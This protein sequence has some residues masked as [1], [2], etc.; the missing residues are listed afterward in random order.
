[1]PIPNPDRRFWKLAILAAGLV[2]A[3][4]GDS[5][6]SGESSGETATEETATETDIAAQTAKEDSAPAGDGDKPQKTRASDGLPGFTGI[7]AANRDAVVNISTTRKVEGSGPAMPERFEGTP[8]EDFF[9][10][11]FEGPE[12][13]TQSLGSG[14]IVSGDGHIVTNAHVVKNASKVVVQLADRRQL[15]AE[16]LGKDLATD[17]AVLKVA[18][19]GLPSL[20]W[21]EGA[22]PQVGEWVL[23]L[24][25][26]FGFEHSATAGI[27]SA[28]GR[29]IPGQAGSYVP[30]LQ[31][32][33]ALN[34]GS[35]GGPLFNPDGEVV[36]VNAQIYSKSGGYMGLSFAIPSKV[37]RDVVA[38][39]RREGEVSHGYLGVAVQDMNRELAR[40]LGLDK[41]RGG[42][43]ARVR[44]GTPA[45]EAGLETG[46]VILAVNGQEIA[47]AGDIPP[48]VGR[49]DPGSEVMLTLL[50]AEQRMDKTVTLGALAEAPGK[51][52]K[53]ASEPTSVLGMRLA[54]VPDELRQR[55]PLPEAG[56][57]LVKGVK[58]GP[59]RRAGIHPGDVILK[60]GDARIE[61]PGRVADLIG[62]VDSG[63]RVPVMIQRG[64]HT[65]FVPL[66]VP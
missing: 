1:M 12:R 23:A 17:L 15:E 56:G 59:A 20:T 64:E 21:S 57:A 43:I 31:T 25:S 10:R 26:P 54:P 16:V 62:R 61:G 22:G 28:R 41:P 33:V 39:I 58:P 34:P 11:F 42:L 5:P 47:Q 55:Q 18:A 52:A 6:S 30:F 19:E 8:F 53:K 60:L 14:F 51:G 35:S 65:L 32:D 38:E 24:G 4:C 36:G 49:M 7:V 45:D 48:L 44:P 3:G 46:D 66:R 37:A 9:R 27:V 29:S 63:A 2:V 40:S 50:R 13:E